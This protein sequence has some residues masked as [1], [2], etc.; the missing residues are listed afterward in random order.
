MTESVAKSTLSRTLLLRNPYTYI[1][2][3]QAGALAAPDAMRIES[4]RRAGEDPN[5]S[6]Q[7]VRHEPENAA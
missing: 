5:A 3:Y 7:C 6:R 4:T 1:Y 2:I